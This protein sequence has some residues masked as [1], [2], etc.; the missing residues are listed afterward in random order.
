MRKMLC[1][2]RGFTLIELLIVVLI[3]AIL[4]AIAIPNFLLFQTRAKVARTLSDIRTCTLAIE[5]YRVDNN[6]V[7]KIRVGGGS[8]DWLWAEN[9]RDPY[10][11]D[12]EHSG[13]LLT[14]PIAY[15]EEPVWDFWNSEMNRKQSPESYG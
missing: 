8:A 14:S 11:M 13:N 12:Y 3:I 7:P 15:I 4:A 5:A 2:R 10:T 1:I 6:A 9:M